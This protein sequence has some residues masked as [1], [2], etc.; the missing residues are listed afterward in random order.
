[1]ANKLEGL[2]TDWFKILF[3]NAYTQT[4]NLSVSG[5]TEKTNYYISLN[6]NGEEGVDKASEY[7]NYGGMVKVNTQLFQGVNMGAIVQVDRRDREMYH[8]SIDLFNY[9][10]R[11]SRAIPLREDNGELYYYMGT[12]T[13]RAHKF[14]IP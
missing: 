13:G 11:V 2:N 4:H 14:N 9:A 6:Y 12:V 1:M 8:S 7:K 10:V 5:G 3:R